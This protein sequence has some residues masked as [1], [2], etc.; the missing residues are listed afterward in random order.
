MKVSDLMNGD[1]VI[2]KGI[3]SEPMQ[4][5]DFNV[6]KG[7]V[8][9]DFQGRG[10]VEKIDNIAS[11]PLTPEI[12]N[13]IGFNLEKFSGDYMTGNWWE[14]PGFLIRENMLESIGKNNFYFEYVHQLQHAFKLCGLTQAI[15]L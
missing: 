6:N 8:F 2:R 10:I 14:S 4:V 12:L 11:I 1:W 3:P 7:L 9:L 13:R 5:V 15:K